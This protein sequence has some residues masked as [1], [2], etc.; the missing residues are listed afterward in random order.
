MKISF[1][2][3][4]YNEAER[5]VRG[6]DGLAAYLKTT[7]WEHEVLV[8]DDGSTD[9]TIELART[10]PLHPTVLPHTKNLGKGAAVQTGALAATGDFILMLDVDLSTPV[11]T[12]DHLLSFT[13]SAD[14]VIGS[15]SIRGAQV[16]TPQHLHKVVLGKLGNLAI[17]LFAV[18]Q[19][20][21]TQNGF[22]LFNRE[23]TKKIFQMQ[24]HT[25][26]GFDFE[27]L[28]LARK[29]GLTVMEVPIVWRNDERS[30][31]RGGDYLRTLLELATLRFDDFRGYYS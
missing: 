28:Y 12:L 16:I 29:E 7:T 25:R 17:R 20:H 24:R 21:D 13:G 31:V 8:V 15:R 5:I 1:V 2:F 22:K 27:L 19:I 9:E 30:K 11:E 6:L 14:I 23:R 26:W 10:H 18:P 4:A 3:P